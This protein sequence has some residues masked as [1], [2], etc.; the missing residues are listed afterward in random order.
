MGGPAG[1]WIFNAVMCK[2]A[3]KLPNGLLRLDQAAAT[4]GWLLLMAIGLVSAAAMW[5]FNRWLEKQEK[6]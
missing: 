3:T 2:D 1:A 5:I 4:R 6:A